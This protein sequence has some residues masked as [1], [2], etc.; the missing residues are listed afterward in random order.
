MRCLWYGAKKT[1]VLNFC[2]FKFI[3]ASWNYHTGTLC[4]E[5]TLNDRQSIHINCK[6]KCVKVTSNL[7]TYRFMNHTNCR[8][9]YTIDLFLFVHLFIILRATDSDRHCPTRTRKVKLLRAVIA[10][11]AHVSAFQPSWLQQHWVKVNV[12]TILRIYY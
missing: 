3:R 4:I 10:F 7:R 6:T 9:I 11:C 2:T 8:G 5:V 12:N 1:P